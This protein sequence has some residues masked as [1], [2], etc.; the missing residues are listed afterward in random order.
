MYNTIITPQVPQTAEYKYQ[1]DKNKLKYI[2]Y[3]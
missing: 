2:K 1:S 3:M